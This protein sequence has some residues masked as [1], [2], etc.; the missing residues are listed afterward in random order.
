MMFINYLA[1]NEKN[2][3]YICCALY[4]INFIKINN[5]LIDGF[6][7][8]VSDYDQKADVYAKIEREK[9]MLT[10]DNQKKASKVLAIFESM[11]FDNLT[12]KKIK[13]DVFSRITPKAQL[14]K[15]R[16]M[17]EGMADKTEYIWDYHYK[18]HLAATINLRPL[19][20]V[21]DFKYSEDN[22]NLKKS[23]D[24]MKLEFKKNK[25]LSE[26]SIDKFQASIIPTKLKKYLIK[27]KQSKKGE[28]IIIVD[29]YR[30]EYFIYQKLY[31]G[32]NAGTVFINSS[33]EYK[34]LDDDLQLDK[35]WRKIKE[36][37]IKNSHVPALE[38]NIHDILKELKDLY[39]YLL[40]RVNT[41]IHNGENKS[42]KIKKN[43]KTGETRWTLPY[44]KMEDE[45]NN[46]FYDSLGQINIIDLLAFVDKMSNFMS[47]FQHIKSHRSQKYKNDPYILACIIANA[48]SLGV[49]K[50]ATSSKLAYEKLFKVQKSHIRLENLCEAN[51]IIMNKTSQLLIFNHYNVM[52]NIIHVSSDGQ[53][54]DTCLQTFIS[55]YLRKYF[56]EKGVSAYTLSIN[57]VPVKTNIIAGH[58][59]HYLY[60]ILI[61]NSSSIQP[62]IVSTD[63]EGANQ[64]NFAFLGLK[65]ILFAPCYKTITSKAKVIGAFKDT[66][67]RSNDIINP[68]EIFNEELIIKEWENVQKIFTSALAGEASQSTIVKKLSSHKRKSKTK[69]AL[70]EYNK[71][72][73]SI[74]LLFYID[75]A[76]FRRCVR[77]SLNRGEAYHQLRRAI[78]NVSGGAFRGKSEMEIRIWNECSRLVAN[79]II[80]YNASMLSQIL[81]IKEKEGDKQAIE[82]LKRISPAAWQHINFLGMYDFSKINVIDIEKILLA[83]MSQL[84]SELSKANMAKAQ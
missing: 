50:M 56:K 44:K 71:I 54:F 76:E 16:I 4:I 19:F 61:N 21:L 32:L 13:K 78:A 30:Y 9:S 68:S 48:T 62:N 40:E 69:D 53:K 25:S 42:I 5:N 34:S 43:K 83:M 26:Y 37:I 20:M 14:K 59:S 47:A 57:H 70:W 11:K 82:F 23:V 64:V 75:N 84:N 81:E 12:L 72:L 36:E 41:R 46:P 33:L 77:I 15:I 18:N 51:E 29:P 49:G 8:T 74:Y 31:Q 38:N 66:K 3:I 52:K 24:F 6:I 2:F 58:E 10:S 1:L 73:M 39:S 60:D 22:D 35:N 65:N 45:V 67:R 63:T 55:R 17:L 27:S 80:Y 7:H 79:A 28:K